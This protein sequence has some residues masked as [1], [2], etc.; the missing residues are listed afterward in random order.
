MFLLH[1]FQRVSAHSGRYQVIP[2]TRELKV[3]AEKPGGKLPFPSMASSQ[4]KSRQTAFLLLLLRAGQLSPDCFICLGLVA[5]PCS[6]GKDWKDEHPSPAAHNP[7]KAQG[8]QQSSLFSFQ[9]H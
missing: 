2:R 4:Y 5:L 9:R 7:M 8:K 1:K 3:S 6:P